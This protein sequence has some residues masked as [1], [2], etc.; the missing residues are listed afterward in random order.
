MPAQQKQSAYSSVWNR[1][2]KPPLMR[3]MVDVLWRNR[4]VCARRVYE[5][6][7]GQSKDGPLL[8][9]GSDMKDSSS[10]RLM[11]RKRWI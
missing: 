9:A 8:R 1:R 11:G 4:A 5:R 6:G 2:R 7:I 10:A 3:P